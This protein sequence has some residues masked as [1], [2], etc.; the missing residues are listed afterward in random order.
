MSVPAP[1][2]SWAARVVLTVL[3]AP[4]FAL[5]WLVGMVPVAVGW[6]CAAVA[7]GWDT[8]RSGSLR[9]RDG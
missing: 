8:A 1:S 2:R 3:V 9:G 5:G 7:E 4:L 6:A